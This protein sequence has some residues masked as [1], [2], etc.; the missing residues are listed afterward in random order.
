MSHCTCGRAPCGQ[1]K[2]YDP[3]AAYKLLL[4]PEDRVRVTGDGKASIVTTD[5]GWEKLTG[6]FDLIA[7]IPA[8]GTIRMS[9]ILYE[10]V[11]VVEP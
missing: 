1:P 8:D 4:V 2:P 7:D 9:R 3:H 6:P 10:T 5:T 11:E